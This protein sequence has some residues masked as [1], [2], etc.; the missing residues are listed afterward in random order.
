MDAILFKYQ[1]ANENEERLKLFVRSF[2]RFR[3]SLANDVRQMQC[4]RA[5][6]SIQ[7]AYRNAV[8]HGIV[9]CWQAGNSEEVVLGTVCR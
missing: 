6:F 7:V 2:L 8:R 9:Y 3:S 5:S 4:R 1:H